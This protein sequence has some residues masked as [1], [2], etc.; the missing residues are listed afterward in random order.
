VLR[1][2]SRAWDSDKQLWEHRLQTKY[3]HIF[4]SYLVNRKQ[5]KTPWP[6]FAS[7]VYRPSDRRLSAKLVPTSANRGNHV[8]SVTVTYG[9]ILGF[10]D[11]SRYYF[12][13]VAPHLYS[14]GWV[15]PVPD[16]LLL[17]K[18]GRAGNRT[19]AS[20]SVA[21]TLTTRPQRLSL[22][23][24]CFG[25]LTEKIMRN[26]VTWS[27]FLKQFVAVSKKRKELGGILGTEGYRITA[28]NINWRG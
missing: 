15:D 12:F 27:F 17:R 21:R 28:H 10:L 25:K 20:R 16:P 9:R 6:E 3:L 22:L 14:R 11:R 19:R 24:R 8:V 26:H 7:E 1:Q 23:S 2:D 13:Q 4:Q 5:T 18:S